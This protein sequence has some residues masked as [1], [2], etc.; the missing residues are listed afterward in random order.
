MKKLIFIL[1]FLLTANA[2][3]E[4][5]DTARM[6]QKLTRITGVQI[7]MNVEKDDGCV[8]NQMK[9]LHKAARNFKRAQRKNLKVYLD[10][11]YNK[12]VIHPTEM[13]GQMEGEMGMVYLKDEYAPYRGYYGDTLKYKTLSRRVV[14]DNRSYNGEENNN[15]FEDMDGALNLYVAKADMKYMQHTFVVLRRN[16]VKRNDQ[17]R[18]IINPDWSYKF[19]SSSDVISALESSNM[20]KKEEKG[21]VECGKLLTWY[22]FGYDAQY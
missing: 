7:D 11:H 15:T 20:E 4:R 19:T 17:L 3:A 14:F 18:T 10:H 21:K 16:V 2:F 5:I 1:T 6:A 13:M 12:M 22:D 9:S 8:Y